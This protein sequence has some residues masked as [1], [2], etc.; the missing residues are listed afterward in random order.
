MVTF[1]AFVGPFALQAVV[2]MIDE[3]ICHHKRGLPRWERLGHPLDTLSVL[4]CFACVAFTRQTPQTLALFAGLSVFSALFVTKDEGV[5][6]ALCGAFEQW[7]HALLFVVHPLIFVT[8]GF[9]WALRD[10]I[11]SAADLGLEAW[12]GAFLEVLLQGQ[13]WVLGGF[14]I[15]QVVFW[16]FIYQRRSS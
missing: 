9:I 16:N 10:G 15:Y 13:V 5:H 11:L 12:Q 3:F 8:S 4:A 6:T 14:L 7:L 2:M 1:V